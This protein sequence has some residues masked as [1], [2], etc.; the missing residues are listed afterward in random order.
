MKRSDLTRQ[1]RLEVRNARMLGVNAEADSPFAGRYVPDDTKAFMEIDI[2]HTYPDYLGPVAMDTGDRGVAVNNL[3][4]FFPDTLEVSHESLLFQ[5]VNLRHILSFYGSKDAPIQS[6]K[7]IGCVVATSVPRKPVMKGWR[8]PGNAEGATACIRACVVIFKMARGVGPLLAKHLTNREPQ[9]VS[10][11]V[12]TRFANL[13]IYHP[14]EDRITPLTEPDEAW[15]KSGAVKEVK[16]AR[17]PLIGKHEG[18]QMFITYGIDGSPVH[19]RGVGVTPNPAERAAEIVSVAAEEAGLPMVGIAAERVP[20]VLA[21]TLVGQ[22][23]TFQ[24]TKRV[25]LITTV[26]TSGEPRLPGA[27]WSRRASELDPVLEIR[28]PDHKCVLRNFSELVDR[29]HG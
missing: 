26:H 5:Q 15:F 28:M 14:G 18:Q 23:V 22:K 21:S 25:G 29:I 2:C 10:I 9:S 1:L 16:G 24:S 12:T 8:V 7:I 4:C 3:C 11:E 20:G 13:G 27:T 19:F 17:M 6:D